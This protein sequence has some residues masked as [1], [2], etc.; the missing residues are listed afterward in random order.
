MDKTTCII[1]GAGPAGAACAY[2]LAKKGIEVIMLERA[3]QTGGKNVASFVMY[4]AILK[5]LIPDYLDDAPF[6]RNVIRSNQVFLGEKDVK[7]IVDFNYRL[8][9]VPIAFTA[10]RGRFDDWLANKAMD[11]GADLITEQTVT[12]L[13]IDKGQVIGVRVDDDELYAD[14][15]VG[16]DG[17][18]SKVAEKAGLVRKWLPERCWHG[19][20][21]ILDLPS[22]VI[23][24]RFQLSDGIG[25]IDSISGYNIDRLTLSDTTLYTNSDSISIGVFGRLGELKDK[26]VKLHEYLEVIKQQPYIHDLI[27]DATLK[28][29]QSHI[30]S[31]GGRVHPNKLYNDGVLLCGEAGGIMDT[32]GV[33]VPTAMLSGMMV[34]ETIEDAIKKG[35]FSSRTLKKYLNYLD[36][37]S[38]LSTIKQSRKDSDY[39]VNGGHSDMAQSMEAGADVFNKNVDLTFDFISKESYPLYLNLYLRVVQYELPKLIRWPIHGILK[40]KILFGRILEKI[41]RKLNGQY[42]EWKTKTDS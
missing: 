8:I 11:A 26:N 30:I 27:K 33:G 9:D 36:S 41:K 35:D 39:I 18:H 25:S 20:K 7:Q 13:I 19:V 28:E 31:D 6:E 32:Y 42:Y 17:Y 22:D 40:S 15:V 5:H 1:V 23:N 21:E 16:A 14:V 29:Y 38:L 3:R 10:F 34:A 24:E 37:T 12:D 4:T 2:V